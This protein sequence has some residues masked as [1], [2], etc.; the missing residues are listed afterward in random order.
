MNE[1]ASKPKETELSQP[2][3]DI[4]ESPPEVAQSRLETVAPKPMP[5]RND[6]VIDLWDLVMFA[7]RWWWVFIVAAIIGLAIAYQEIRGTVPMYTATLVIAPK[8]EGNDREGQGNSQVQQIAAQFG[9]GTL[10]AAEFTN[11][12]RFRIQLKS[13]K[14]AEE[15]DRNSNLFLQLMGGRWDS[16]TKQWEPP[17]SLRFKIAS[18]VKSHLGIPAWHAPDMADF[19][20]HLSSNIAINKYKEVYYKMEFSHPNRDIA[21]STLS[22]AISAGEKILRDADERYARRNIEYLLGRLAQTPVLDARSA[23]TNLIGQEEQRLMMLKGMENYLGRVVNQLE[24]RDR[25]TYPPLMSI[26]IK[27]VV[28]VCGFA[29]FVVILGSLFHL[30]S[31]RRSKN[32]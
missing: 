23:I 31:R 16:E 25:P 27:W 1:A 28:I 4:Q 29:F 5:A 21:I 7:I 8:G 19:A 22:T 18:Y 6:D 32:S 20:E 12:D 13:R 17:S 14:L 10:G 11:V 24:A 26:T 9:V 2:D 30:E 3:G 15:V